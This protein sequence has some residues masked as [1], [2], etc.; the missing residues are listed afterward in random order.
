MEHEKFK[1]YIKDLGFI[2]KEMALQAK[3]N[4]K[5][6]DHSS[7]EYN[8]QLG[9]LMAFHEI[10]DLMKQQAK[11]FQISQEELS[12]SDLDPETDLL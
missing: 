8:Y 3:K 6:S 1:N 4:K 9:Y 7:E 10:I 5:I 12:L 11:N 2:L